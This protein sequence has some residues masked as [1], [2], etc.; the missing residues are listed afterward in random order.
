MDVIPHGHL[1]AQPDLQP[2]MKS[3]MFSLHQAMSHC[4]SIPGLVNAYCKVNNYVSYTPVQPN[5]RLKK[6]FP[7]DRLH[8]NELMTL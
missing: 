2:Y 6:N 7:R 4:F 5:K 1:C 3:V 8:L